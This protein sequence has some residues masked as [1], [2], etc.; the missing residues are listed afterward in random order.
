MTKPLQCYQC[1]TS[2]EKLSLPLRRLDE[3]PE[4]LRELHVCRMCLFYDA[5]HP[6]NCIE[7]EA[8]EIREME[9]A[10]F[11]DY[12]K[13]SPNAYTPESF[14]AEQN[15]KKK[16]TKLFAGVDSEAISTEQ[17]TGPDYDKSNWTEVEDL[18]KK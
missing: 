5:H 11:C 14:E 2:L 7:E 6:K 1:G 10:N 4:C 3:C 13:P 12:F 9:R 16:L 18:F 8:P 17:S 15:A